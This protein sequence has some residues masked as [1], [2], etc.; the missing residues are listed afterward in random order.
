[1]PENKCDKNGNSVFVRSEIVVKAT[2]V[3]EENS[4]EIIIVELEK[5]TV[6]SIYKPPFVLEKP[7]HFNFENINTVLGDFNGRNVNW[8]YADT[9]M[10][11]ENIEC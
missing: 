7:R 5:W 2:A 10:D 3:T 6:A 4:F 11:G 1:M 9:D 8:G